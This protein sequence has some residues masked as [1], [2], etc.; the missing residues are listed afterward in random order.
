[1]FYVPCF[2]VLL[3]L[4]T[5]FKIFRLGSNF[6]KI[7]LLNSLNYKIILRF[8]LFRCLHGV[9]SAN[10][11]N[12]RAGKDFRV[13][14]LW[15]WRERTKSI[16]VIRLYGPKTSQ[17]LDLNSSGRAESIRTI[18]L[19]NLEMLWSYYLATETFQFVSKGGNKLQIMRGRT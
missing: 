4:N 8:W 2:L 12:S 19:S 10:L 6:F 5:I 15:N 17:F 1:M 9:Q 14:N 13:L 11:N 7:P 18:K 16:L 3:K